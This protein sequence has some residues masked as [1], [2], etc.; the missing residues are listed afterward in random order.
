MEPLC[1][2]CGAAAAVVW[3]YVTTAGVEIDRDCLCGRHAQ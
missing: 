2:I 1:S 3:R